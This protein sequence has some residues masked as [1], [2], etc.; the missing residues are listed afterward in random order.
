LS[1]PISHLLGD[2]QSSMQKVVGVLNSL[3]EKKNN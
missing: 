3:K 2:L 1:Y